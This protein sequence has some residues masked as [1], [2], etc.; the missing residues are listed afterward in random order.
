MQNSNP[1]IDKRRIKY[2]ESVIRYTQRM[3]ILTLINCS[4]LLQR[5]LVGKEVGR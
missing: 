4:T 2:N 1:L 5:L 3:P